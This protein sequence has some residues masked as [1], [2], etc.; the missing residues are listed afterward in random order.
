MAKQLYHLANIRELLTQ[1]FDDEELR[2]LCFDVPDFRPVYD[3]LAKNSG[4]DEIVARLLEHA[5]KWLV[6][7]KLLGL[8][9]AHNAARYEAHGPYIYEAEEDARPLSKEMQLLAALPLETIPEVAPLPRRSRMPLSPNPLF[10]GRED[11]LMALAKTLKVGGTAA[12]GQIAA[13]TGLGGIG[14]TQLATEFTHRYGQYFA[15]GVF[16]LSFAEEAGVPSEVTACGGPAGMGLYTEASGLNLEEQVQMVRAAWQE[17]TP[18]LLVF[19]NCEEE[20]LLAEWRPRTGGCRVVVTS[21]RGKWDPALGVK[22]LPLGVLPRSKSIELLR[23]F[24]PDLAEVDPDL[25]A[26][27]EELGDLPLALY[28]AGSWLEQTVTRPPMHTPADEVW[29]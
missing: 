26:I 22:E 2:A 19:D 11:D 10:V 17:A 5:E 28:V 29:L 1:G 6:I 16:W 8:A 24:Q 14:K 20:Q 23:K 12:V 3:R 27:A 25:T 4:K 18:R 21:R 15:G 7:D 9:K 13:A